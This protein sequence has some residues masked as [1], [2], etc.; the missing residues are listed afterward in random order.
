M[1]K[2]L[3]ANC[4]Q[5]KIILQATVLLIL[6]F[7]AAVFAQKQP[8]DSTKIKLGPLFKKDELLEL[9]LTANLKTLLKDRKDAKAPYRWAT[10][11][12]LDPQ[13][14]L[15]S[16]KIKVKTRGNF[17]R[18]ASNCGFPPLLLNIPS[19]KDKGTVFEHQNLLKL[20]THCQDEA[21]VFQEYL[22]Y[23]MYNLLTEES[24]KARLAKVTYQDSAG[25]LKPE[26]KYAFLLED[27]TTLAK[28]NK[29]ENAN[30]KQLPMYLIDSTSMATVSIFEYLIGNTDWSL[31]FLHNIKLLSRKD[32]PLLAVP[33]DF[34]HSGIVEANYA[35][36]AEA[37]EL[38][39]VKQ[40]LYRGITYDMALFQ[41]VFDN[42]RRVKPQIYALYEGNPLLDA[43]YIKRT[44]KYLDAFYAT[45]DDPKSL[46]KTFIEGGKKN[47]LQVIIK[48][49]N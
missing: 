47:G 17:R 40:R 39:S 48:G 37:L 19:K 24:F 23:K 2:Q 16:L 33:Y 34:D 49:L 25:K 31:P 10:V 12:C 14:G 15:D 11:Q 9:K 46:K 27:E 30:R 7:S 35:R 32:V 45:I 26:T 6:A 21:Y 20:I 36:P 1:T 41:K 18:L 42:F 4:P 28:R 22:V 44:I 43:G 3:L 38:N 13:N 29:A 8:K 5:F